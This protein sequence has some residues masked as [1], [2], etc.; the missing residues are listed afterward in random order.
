MKHIKKFAFQESIIENISDIFVTLEEQGYTVRAKFSKIV[1]G[2]DNWGVGN[3]RKIF[4]SRFIPYNGDVITSKNDIIENLLIVRAIKLSYIKDIDLIPEGQ[5]VIDHWEKIDSDMIKYID[6]IKKRAKLFL[7][8]DLYGVN[9]EW[10]Q[11]GKIQ[12][13]E[14][15]GEAVHDVYNFVFKEN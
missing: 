1:I 7:N 13:M 4:G 5:A 14:D 6:L 10:Y 8:L 12:Y 11:L 9:A 3:F 2:R 15:K